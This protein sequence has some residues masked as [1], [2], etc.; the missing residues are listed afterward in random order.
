MKLPS[1][2]YRK[3]VSKLEAFRGCWPYQ[4]RE[5]NMFYLFIHSLISLTEIVFIG[6]QFARVVSEDF[7]LSLEAL[8][9][10][11]VTEIGFLKLFMSWIYRKK[12][13]EIYDR[14]NSDWDTFT[15]RDEVE[16]LDKFSQEALEIF[17]LYAGLLLLSV[18]G[19]GGISVMREHFKYL[20]VANTTFRTMDLPIPAYYFG[21]ESGYHIKLTQQ[22]IAGFGCIFLHLAHDTAYNG[23]VHH[24]CSILEISKVHLKRTSEILLRMQKFSTFDKTEYIKALNNKIVSAIKVHGRALE[25]V[26]IIES[27][28]RMTWLLVLVQNM[29]GTGISLM[30]IAHKTDDLIELIRYT[31][32]IFSIALHFYIVYLPGQKLI[33][34]S[35]G[36]GDAFYE[37]E[38]YNFP[39]G[40]R[41]LLIPVIQRS[42]RYCYLTGGGFFQLCMETYFE[43]MKKGFS[44]FTVL[45][46][47]LNE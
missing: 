30:I 1:L 36:V 41:K 43:M 40:I 29:I 11:L 2:D 5:K 46:T 12:Q 16:V 14:I 32:P 4:N 35:L 17:L 33:D 10:F 37:C 27:Y 23:Q 20:F 22:F 21:I 25:L 39:P 8:G 19:F 26:P 44:I 28:Y 7:V 31:I 45:S 9:A 34:T 24:V 18:T 47:F 13:K 42:Q 15:D 6:T 38:W 3:T